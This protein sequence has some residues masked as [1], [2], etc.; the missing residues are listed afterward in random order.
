MDHCIKQFYNHI[1]NNII[2]NLNSTHDYLQNDVPRSKIAS[3][4]TIN[5]RIYDF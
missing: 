2:R 1:S 3:R 5:G 4:M